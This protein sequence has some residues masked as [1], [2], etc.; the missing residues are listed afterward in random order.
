[1][2]MMV[3]VLCYLEL[4]TAGKQVS[5]T[6]VLLTSLSCCKADI[7][8]CKRIIADVCGFIL[9]LGIVADEDAFAPA[10]YAVLYDGPC[11]CGTNDQK[12]KQHDHYILKSFATHTSL[13]VLYF[14][15]SFTNIVISWSAFK[16]IVFFTL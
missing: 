7:P 3:M 15:K 9:V 6:S 11:C 2:V 14:N 10:A 13:H 4:I 5:Y 8:S 12:I 1:M 16:N